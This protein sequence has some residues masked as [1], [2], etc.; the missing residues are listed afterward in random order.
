V[1]DWGDLPPTPWHCRGSDGRMYAGDGR[2]TVMDAEFSTV[3]ETR[4]PIHSLPWPRETAERLTLLLSK[5][6]LIPRL[7]A[8]LD[9][10]IPEGGPLRCTCTGDDCPHDVAAALL[11]EL[12]ADA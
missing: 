7:E 10:F 1:K 11:A 6:Y 3:A 12:R 5:A 9:A 8:A 2:F 4:V